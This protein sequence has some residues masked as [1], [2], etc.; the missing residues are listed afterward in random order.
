MKVSLKKNLK[1]VIFCNENHSN[2]DEL[3][4]VINPCIYISRLAIMVLDQ[5]SLMALPT[6]I[7]K[8]F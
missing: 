6:F 8:H 1:A 5:L 3:M 4:I 7:F 2:C